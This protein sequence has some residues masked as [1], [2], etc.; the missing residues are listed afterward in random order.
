MLAVACSRVKQAADL[1]IIGFN[2][3]RLI[4]H[5]NSTISEF[6]NQPNHHYTTTCCN[7]TQYQPSTTTISKTDMDLLLKDIN[8]DEEILNYTDTLGIPATSS[9]T[10]GSQPSTSDSKTIVMKPQVL[11]W[12]TDSTLHIYEEK[13]TD[14]VLQ[15]DKKSKFTPLKHLRWP[16]YTFRKQCMDFTMFILVSHLQG[17]CANK[18]Y[19][20]TWNK[21][22]QIPHKWTIPNRSKNNV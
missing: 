10:T 13:Q 22:T 2:Q 17:H 21:H 4:K 18:T 15:T 20:R 9:T 12:T 7:P 5:P 8:W 19:K 1:N 6:Y 11:S 3:H 14:L 16:N